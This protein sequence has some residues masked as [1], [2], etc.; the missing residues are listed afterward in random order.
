MVQQLDVVSDSVDD[1]NAFENAFHVEATELVDEQQ[2]MAYL[3]L[4]TA[5][6]WKI[7]NKNVQNRAGESVGYE[8]LPGENSLRF[9]TPNAWWRRRAG[10]WDHHLWVT[11]YHDREN[12][13]A[14]DY[15]NQHQGGAGLPAYTAHNRAIENSDLVVWY[16]MGHHH[17]PR[18]EDWPVM[19][20]SRIGF[21]LKPLGFFDRNPALD[22]PP[23]MAHGACCHGE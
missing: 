22:V 21:M 2:A 8:F 7:I 12:Y 3:N 1:S 5:R 23:E 20:V 6:T 16:T 9:A 4:E 17:L 19:P 14:G 11:P 18:P 15:P 13:A 10:F